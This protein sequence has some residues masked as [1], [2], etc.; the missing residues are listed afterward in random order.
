MNQSMN[1]NTDVMDVLIIPREK[2]IKKNV[3]N[4]TFQDIISLI[5]HTFI[6]MIQEPSHPDY[7]NWKKYYQEFERDY[8]KQNKE[9]WPQI[10]IT[11]NDHKKRIDIVSLSDDFIISTNFLMQLLK[12]LYVENYKRSYVYKAYKYHKILSYKI[13]KNGINKVQTL[14]IHDIFDILKKFMLYYMR[15]Y[16]NQQNFEYILAKSIFD[17][18][19]D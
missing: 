7:H 16:N 15:I 3:E 10:V 1:Q 13:K 11:R 5:F 2:I 14:S 6:Y 19:F 8:E 18:L 9:T 4:I 12:M 17:Q